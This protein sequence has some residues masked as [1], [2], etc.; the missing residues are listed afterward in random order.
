MLGNEKPKHAERVKGATE[1]LLRPRGFQV[2]FSFS[3]K[4]KN[5]NCF[6]NNPEH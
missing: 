2:Q 1:N 3:K 4:K 5:K 6:Q